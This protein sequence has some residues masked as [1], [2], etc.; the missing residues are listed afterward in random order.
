[1]TAFYDSFFGKGTKIARLWQ[2]II[3]SNSIHFLFYASLHEKIDG[4]LKVSFIKNKT[5]RLYSPKLAA[6]SKGL[7]KS[8]GFLIG[9]LKVLFVSI[10]IYLDLFRSCL[11]Y[12]SD[13]ADE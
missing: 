7:V 12:T 2:K 10:C 11:L 9:L 3:H 8:K 5:V 13:A 1:M 6:A 4:F